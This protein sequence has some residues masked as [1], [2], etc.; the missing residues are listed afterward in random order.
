MIRESTKQDIDRVVEIWL[1]TSLLAHSFIDS[2]YWI[3]NREAMRNTYI[4]SCKTYVYVDDDSQQIVGFASVAENYLAALFVTPSMQ[5]KGIGRK[6]MNYLKQFLSSID[7]TVYSKNIPSI[8]FYQREG[9][10]FI[11]ERIDK[12]TKEK[13]WVMKYDSSLHTSHQQ[14][15]RSEKK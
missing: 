6:L 4:P 15:D 14:P 12:N 10:N 3:A 2:D 13:E 5:G 11:E 9:F 8:A 1:E 7:L